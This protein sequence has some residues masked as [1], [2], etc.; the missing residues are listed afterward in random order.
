LKWQNIE[1]ILESNVRRSDG[2]YVL[3]YVYGPLPHRYDEY[4]A[5]PFHGD[6][7]LLSPMKGDKS[8][9]D[10]ESFIKLPISS[11]TRVMS[12]M[13][14]SGFSIS[15][16]D[17]QK[18]REEYIRMNNCL[19]V[20][21]DYASITSLLESGFHFN[22]CTFMK[23]GVIL[24]I[25][26]RSRLWSNDR[27]LLSVVGNGLA[28]QMMDVI[29]GFEKY[30]ISDAPTVHGTV[31]HQAIAYGS[32]D[33]TL[34]RFVETVGKRRTNLYRK[35]KGKTA[36][37]TFWTHSTS[38]IIMASFSGNKAYLVPLASTDLNTVMESAEIMENS[39]GIFLGS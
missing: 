15:S 30:I 6:L 18:T 29:N 25:N 28:N 34:S 35:M 23:E 20:G 36:Y 13:E 5:I 38:N 4:I 10:I 12:D 24:G 19:D 31:S 37:I 16:L 8:G 2:F 7:R 21:L 26:S 3:R 11:L 9:D 39:G 32:F 33:D 1:E 27:N 14:E 22:S 17:M